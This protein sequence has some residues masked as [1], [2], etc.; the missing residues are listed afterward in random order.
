MHLPTM[1]RN[2]SDRHGSV[3]AGLLTFTG[4]GTGSITFILYIQPHH[5]IALR[6]DM[7]RKHGDSLRP[8]FCHIKAVDLQTL[9]CGL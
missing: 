1:W 5:C 9:N 3:P 4:H 6:Q 2:A 8:P 7:L